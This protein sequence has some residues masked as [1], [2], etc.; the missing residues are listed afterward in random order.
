MIFPVFSW[1]RDSSD[2]ADHCLV[3]QP[4]PDVRLLLLLPENQEAPY[5]IGTNTEAAALRSPAHLLYTVQV[6]ITLG[7]C[8]LG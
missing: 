2:P 8:S 1:A 3:C 6:V 7:R 4:G 5:G